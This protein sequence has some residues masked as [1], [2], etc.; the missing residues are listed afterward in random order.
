M[1]SV[2]I[3]GSLISAKQLLETIEQ[4]ATAASIQANFFMV[5]TVLEGG[6][7]ADEIFGLYWRAGN[8]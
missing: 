7:M 2:K 1:W 8:R 4:E 6:G 3:L 5:S